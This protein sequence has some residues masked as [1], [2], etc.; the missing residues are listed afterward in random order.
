LSHGHLL[1]KSYVTTPFSGHYGSGL[2]ATPTTDQ[3]ASLPAM[4]PP[5]HPRFRFLLS[6]TTR[7]ENPVAAVRQSMLEPP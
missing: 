2:S 7:I 4:K 1:L 6:K 5:I 3:P